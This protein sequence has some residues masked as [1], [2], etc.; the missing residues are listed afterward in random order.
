MEHRN[1][2]WTDCTSYLK[3][4]NTG[5]TFDSGFW[6]RKMFRPGYAIE[7]DYFPPQQLNLSLETKI[8][9]NL[10]FAGQ[11][12]GT[13]GYEEAACQGL[14]G[15]NKCSLKINEKERVCSQE[16]WNLYW[17]FNW[18]PGYKGTDEPYRMFTSRAEFRTLLRQDNADIRLTPVSHRLGPRLRW[19]IK[20]CRKKKY[21]EQ[22]N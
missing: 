8:I 10:Y 20:A 21:L 17:C 6:E 11:I 4:F 22:M 9:Q 12:N 19:K 14:D 13:T 16:I 2:F 7:Y 15:R 1:L 18:R 3:T 5:F